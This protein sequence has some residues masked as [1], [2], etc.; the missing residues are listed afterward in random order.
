MRK[1]GQIVAISTSFG[2][3]SWISLWR[4]IVARDW[5]L[6]SSQKVKKTKF[7]DRLAVC[8]AARRHLKRKQNNRGSANQGPA[9]H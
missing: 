2:P 4:C 3:P 1:N 9:V 8:V 6:R 7:E 5:V